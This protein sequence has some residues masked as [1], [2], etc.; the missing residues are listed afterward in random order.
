MTRRSNKKTYYWQCSFA[1]H[2]HQSQATARKCEAKKASARPIRRWEDSE[3]QEALSKYVA[4][5]SV[6]AIARH[7]GVSHY[8]MSAR[9]RHHIMWRLL[10][11]GEEP[12]YGDAS[13]LR[14]DAKRALYLPPCADR[15]CDL[16]KSA[17]YIN[18]FAGA[19]R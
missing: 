3:I 10:F 17:S 9:L 2:R 18:Y 16:V 14:R 12:S 8:C 13:A 5:Q 19:H 1:G 11:A 4:G 7:F 6:A 15:Y